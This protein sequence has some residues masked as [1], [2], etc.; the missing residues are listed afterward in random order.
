MKK[1]SLLSALALSCGLVAATPANAFS[2]S[3]VVDNDFA[4]Y[5]G[6]STSINNL[7]YQ[8]NDVWNTQ[9]STLGTLNFNLSAGDTTFYVLAMGGGG[10]ENISGKINGVN[11]TSSAVHVAMSQDIRSYLT[12]YNTGTVTD[13]TFNPLLAD[14]QNAFSNTVWGS[15]ILNS[16]E[17][18]ISGSGFGSGFRFEN[19]TAHLFSFSAADVGVTQRV[20]EPASLSLLGL[21]LLGLVASRRRKTA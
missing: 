20:P 14:V 17:I 3:M 5:G 9:I 6:T 19:Q 10:Q 7:I 12:N 18:V 1:S 16:S 15:P 8:N 21:G 11:I 2:I 4:I 13:G